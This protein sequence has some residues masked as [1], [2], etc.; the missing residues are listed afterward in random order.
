[1][2]TSEN[3]HLIWGLENNERQTCLTA[4]ILKKIQGVTQ[5]QG[6]PLADRKYQ[7]L[8]GGF[9]SAI[10]SKKKKLSSGSYKRK[11]K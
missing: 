11:F 2:E 3:T 4:V 9:F 10:L 5:L 1:M 7:T 6:I 8:K